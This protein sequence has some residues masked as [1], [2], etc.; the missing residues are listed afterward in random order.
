M[1]TAQLRRTPPQRRPRVA[2]LLPRPIRLRHLHLGPCW[3]PADWLAARQPARRPAGQAGW[4]RTHRAFPGNE[5]GDHLRVTA[6]LIR[7]DNGY[8]LWSE[9][10]D[11]QLDDVSRCKD[12]IGGAV[13]RA[14][15]VTLLEGESPSATPTTS[16]A[17]NDLYLQAG[18]FV[19]SNA[20]PLI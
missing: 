1:S 10:Y 16:I 3:C 7:A 15:K 8:H 6:Q 20:A 12:E 5:S 18:P 17:A 9:T 19:V 13:V 14:L 4:D 2:Q 11:R